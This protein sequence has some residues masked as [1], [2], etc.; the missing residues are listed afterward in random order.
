MKQ[1]FGRSNGV[2]AMPTWAAATFLQ[3]HRLAGQRRL[4]D[5]QVLG[6]DQSKVGRDHVACRQQDDVARH[7]LLDRHVS[8]VVRVRFSLPAHGRGYRHHPLQPVGGIVG[9]MFLDEAQRDA[10]KHHDGNHDRRPLIAQ[11]IGYRREREQQQVQRVDRVADELA[12]NRMARLMCDLIRSRCAEPVFDLVGRE[13][14]CGTRKPLQCVAGRKT[15]DFAQGF[16]ARGQSFGC[17]GRPVLLTSKGRLYCCR[18]GL[19]HAAICD[20][21]RREDDVPP[22]MLSTWQIQERLTI[23][24][25]RPGRAQQRS[26]RVN[27]PRLP[28]LIRRDRFDVFEH[29]RMHIVEQHVD[30]AEY[31]FDA[32][33]R[34]FD[35]R[36]IANRNLQDLRVIQLDH[37]F[38][39]RGKSHPIIFR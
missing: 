30:F 21:Q 31:A 13:A 4:V 12:E 37:D 8:G 7:E 3:R 1:M 29:S 27:A 22:V 26:V 39:A 20:Q 16:A 24:S 10:Q 23:L 18:A 34:S 19:V 35:R 32:R 38:P 25:V 14:V 28:E 15:R 36:G 9:T 5:E 6:R 2:S 17:I 33:E 11:Y